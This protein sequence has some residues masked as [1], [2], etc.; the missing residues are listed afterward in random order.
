MVARGSNVLVSDHGFRGAALSLERGCG[1]VHLQ[2]AVGHERLV[3]AGGGVRL[4][5]VVE[6][7]TIH[8][9]GGIQQFAGKR[10]TVGGLISTGELSGIVL[11]TV[12]ADASGTQVILSAT[13]N[14]KDGEPA[15]LYRN[16]RLALLQRNA[17]C[18]LNIPGSGLA[19]RDPENGKAVQHLLDASCGGI[20]VGGAMSHR[21][22]P[23]L[24]I[25]TGTAAPDDILNLVTEMKERTL[26]Q[27]GIDLQLLIRP[28]GFHGTRGGSLR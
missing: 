25:N 7:C 18:P 9:I 4:A 22:H 24:V 21:D 15:E 16:Q 27:T 26:R 14:L 10:G 19:F 28:V 17:E 11:D 6:F 5:K 13:L 2:S 23:N 20:T 3:V 12:S 8:G 1:F